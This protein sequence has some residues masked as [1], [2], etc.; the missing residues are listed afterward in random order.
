MLAHFYHVWA[1]GAWQDAVAEHLAA[2]E[3]SGLG[4]ALDCKAAGIVGTPANRAEVIKVLDEWELAASADAG[5]EDVTLRALHAY[6]RSHDGGVFYAHTKGASD[7][8]RQNI[9]WRRR[10]TWYCAGQWVQAVAALDSHDCAGPHWLAVAA[11]YPAGPGHPR[12]GHPGRSWVAWF[13]GNF[14]WANLGFLRRLTPLADGDRWEAERWIG[15]SGPVDAW[16]MCPGWPTDGLE[17]TC[18][19]VDAWRHGETMLTK[20]DERAPAVA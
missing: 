11:G 5:F 10:M 20:G 12:P 18:G 4:A 13:G 14:W 6:S 15:E 3:V 1:D 9:L 8:S 16:D 17:A 7:P 19:Q 2:L